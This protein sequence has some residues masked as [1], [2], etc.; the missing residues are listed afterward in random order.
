MLGHLLKSEKLREFLAVLIYPVFGVVL[1]Y[2][3]VV[4]SMRAQDDYLLWS[5]INNWP[6]THGV[7]SA[8]IGYSCPVKRS[9]QYSIQVQRSNEYFRYAYHVQNR[10]YFGTRYS[11]FG[12]C[13]LAWQAQRDFQRTSSKGRVVSVFFNPLNPKESVLA[14]SS[15]SYS[16]IF[17][18]L[19][20]LVVAFLTLRV[21]IYLRWS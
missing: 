8:D 20:C 19:M 11:Q 17:P 14:Q 3:G 13:T 5:A 16:H 10:T 15:W 7:M 12:F 18:A 4:L 6:Q 21:I 9:L 2:F 1:L